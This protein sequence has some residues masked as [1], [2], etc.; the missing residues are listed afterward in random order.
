MAKEK[1]Y[2]SSIKNYFNKN[3]KKIG[4]I[5]F[6]YA[7]MGGQSVELALKGKLNTTQ[8]SKVKTEVLNILNE[9]FYGE[10]EIGKI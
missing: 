10:Y 5:K 1:A 3:V 6:E 2:T 8:Q 4:S 7:E 9:N